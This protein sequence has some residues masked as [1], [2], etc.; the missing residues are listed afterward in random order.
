MPPRSTAQRY[1]EGVGVDHGALL[2]RLCRDFPDG[3]A[4]STSSPAL[5][6]VL[7]LP[8]C[9]PDVRVMAWVK[10]WAVF[11]PGVNPAYA[12]EPVLVRDGRRRTRTQ[13]TVRDWVS[14]NATQRWGLAG[15]KPYAFSAWL[16]AVLGLEPH[17]QLVDLFPGTG[18][19]T[20]A[21]DRW[22]AR[23]LAA[24]GRQKACAVCG[25]AFVATRRDAVA[26]SG[27]C[28]QAA[29]RRRGAS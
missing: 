18:A 5:R 27:R 8:E 24:A 9:P 12:W 26:C 14:A 17:D 20:R 3:W 13:P 4:L 7:A 21:C 6:L 22:R 10:P 11:K 2:A 16:F 25:R 15:A 19:V 29:Y 28:R 1:P 23:E